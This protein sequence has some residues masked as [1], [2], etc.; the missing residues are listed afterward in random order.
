M[1]LFLLL[2]LLL[3]LLGF[4]SVNNAFVTTTTTTSSWTRMVGGGDISHVAAGAA[5][6]SSSIKSSTIT[7]LQMFHSSSSNNKNRKRSKQKEQQPKEQS[8][9]NKSRITRTIESYVDWLELF[10]YDNDYDDDDND[11]NDE[12]NNKKKITVVTFHASWCKYC[13]KFNRKWDRK[14]VRPYYNNNNNKNVLLQDAT[15]Q[16]ASVEFGRNQKLCQSLHI[17]KLPTVQFYYS[18]NGNN[19][20]L[21]SSM[22]CGPNGGFSTIQKIMS[23]Y[24]KMND[25]ELQE[26][27][28][29]WEQQQQQQQSEKRTAAPVVP[30]AMEEKEENDI[31]LSLSDPQDVT[32]ISDDENSYYEPDLYLRKRDRLRKKLSRRGGKTQQQRT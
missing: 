30:V 28:H 9:I 1:T 19:L 14:M 17:E 32:I 24:L 21:L 15:I 18:C 20:L 5:P 31:S 12:N 3:L 10:D 8:N 13:Q 22:P 26:E 25:D 29:Q 16:F 7:A 2:L 4:V 23:I 27:A 6:G 11:D